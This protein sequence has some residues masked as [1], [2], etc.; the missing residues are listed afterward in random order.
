[1]KRVYTLPE[2][3][4]I[5]PMV[6][7][8]AAE[9]VERRARRRQLSE[10]REELESCRTPEGLLQ[11]LAE[12]DAQV[13]EQDEALRRCRTELEGL[14]MTVLRQTPLTVHISGS[15][16]SGPVV[17]CWQESE[18]SVCH[19]HP[20]GQEQEHRRPLKIKSA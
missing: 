9:M 8:I 15:S 1:M 19:G 10:L 7:T 5:L 4:A 16:R 11:S 13:F 14:G 17:F 12:V 18:D 6:R 20:V 2:A 3:N